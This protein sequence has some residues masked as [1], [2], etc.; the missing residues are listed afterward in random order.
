MSFMTVNSAD[1]NEKPHFCAISYSSS[2]FV[3][4][5]HV[6]GDCT[7]GLKVSMIKYHNQVLQ[8]KPRRRYQGRAIKSKVLSFLWGIA[9]WKASHRGNMSQTV[10]SS[11]NTDQIVPVGAVW[12]VFT[13]LD[14]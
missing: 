1:T 4:F 5:I 2:L 7:K 12:S 9:Q 8:T 3:L 11:V 10:P 13:L 14:T 6:F